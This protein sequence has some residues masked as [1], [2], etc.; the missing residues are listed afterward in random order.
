MLD[1]LSPS[2]GAEVGSMAERILSFYEPLADHY[3]LIFDDWNSAIERQAKILNA[4]LAAQMRGHPLKILDCA[5]GIGTQALGLAAF[6]HQVIASDL[7]QAEVNR[8]KHEAEIRALDISFHASDMTSLAEIADR[9]FDVVAALDNAL[10]HLTADQLSRAVEAV[11]SKLKSNGLFI[12]SI[13]DYDTLILERPTIQ[14]P[15]FYGAKG[16]RRIVHQ[17]WDWIDDTRYA[18]HLYITMQSDQE[19]KSHHFVSEYR[20]LL[21][22]ELSN[23]LQS[24]GFR[25]VRWL[26]PA[27]SGF[28]QPLVLARRA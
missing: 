23:V 18:L 2:E 6:G 19:W 8:A 14:E 22:N 24:T 17:V 25:E 28:Y 20:C 16:D 3:H 9:D 13:R 15:A 27:E 5:C 7:S 10:P 12:A 21:R 4:L 1:K 11:G 26:M